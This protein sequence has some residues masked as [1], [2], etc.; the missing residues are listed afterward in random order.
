VTVNGRAAFHEGEY[1]WG[2]VGTNNLSSAQWPSATVV[3]GGHTNAGNLYLAQTPEEFSYD[4]DGNLTNDGRWVYT[5]DAENRLIGM[6]VNTNV[7]PQYQ[8]SFVYDSKGRRIQ[9]LVLSNS[10]AL[11]TNNFL[12][13]GWNLAATL[14]A[15]SSIIE[16]FIWD[17]DLSASMQGAGGVGGLLMVSYF[18]SSTT[19]CYPAYDGNGNVSALINAADGTLAANYEYGPFG[20]VLR[21]TGSMAKANPFRFSTKYEDDES[22]LLYYG[23]RYYKPSTGTWVNRDPIA[24]KGGINLY[25]FSRN[26]SVNH[27]DHLGL[28][29]TPPTVLGCIPAPWKTTYGTPYYVT[30]Y[31]VNTAT[32][33]YSCNIKIARDKTAWKYCF[34]CPGGGPFSPF[35]NLFALYWVSTTTQET[36][37]Y[38]DDGAAHPTAFDPAT[39][40]ASYWSANMP[41]GT[42]TW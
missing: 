2:T 16:S 41:T 23:Y 29:Y 30:G 14:N 33:C 6:T 3:S 35:D 15:Q 39:T 38:A 42:P 13:D 22:D 27:I 26:D 12:Y 24:E 36:K 17:S 40:C 10:V 4:A 34:A 9:K 19:N 11:Y 1:F 8:L 32:M 31:E 28:A 37:P 7:G 25:G 21:S 20:E 18:G 5:W